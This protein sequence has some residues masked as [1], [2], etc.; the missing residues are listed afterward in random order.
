MV[1]PRVEDT[2]KR[3][4]PWGISKVDEMISLILQ[5]KQLVLVHEEQGQQ[6]GLVV[7]VLRTWH[8]DMVLAL[9]G[10]E[11]AVLAVPRLSFSLLLPHNL[12]T[13]FSFACTFQTGDCLFIWHC[14]SYSCQ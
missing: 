4:R 5:G 6:L 12:V 3:Y 13:W 1:V 9:W 10:K 2:D 7:A 14:T 11:L 8:E